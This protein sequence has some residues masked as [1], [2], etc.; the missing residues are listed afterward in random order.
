M[1][2]KEKALQTDEKV[3]ELLSYNQRAIQLSE[4]LKK[5]PDNEWVRKERDELNKNHIDPLVSSI[6]PELKDLGL[7]LSELDDEIKNTY[8]RQI[9]SNQGKT[10]DVL[11]EEVEMLYKVI[12]D[13]TLYNALM[14]RVLPQALEQAHI[15]KEE[16]EK[17]IQQINDKTENISYSA[18]VV[19][20]RAECG[21]DFNKPEVRQA[22]FKNAVS[23]MMENDK[24]LLNK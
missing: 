10:S 18:Y 20:E 9:L 19:L 22:F 1:N 3:Q 12:S 16:Y 23:R 5:V 4:T 21:S 14:K 11:D 7:F 13:D 17:M 15:S 2:Y 6:L 24:T 8:L